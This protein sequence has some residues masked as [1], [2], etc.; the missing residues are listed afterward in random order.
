MSIVVRY[1]GA[2][3]L[4]KLK[5]D[6]TIRRLTAEGLM[7]ADGLQYHIAFGSDGHF[8]VSEIWDSRE[9]LEAFT[10][11]LMPILAASG[12]ELAAPPGD[13]RRPQYH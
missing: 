13:R 10:S 5:Y 11:R 6:E 7:P 8:R 3:S 9:K 12:V 4:T 1:T 2:P